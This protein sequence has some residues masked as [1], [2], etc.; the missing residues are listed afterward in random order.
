M[1]SREFELFRTPRYGYT[2]YAVG[3]LFGHVVLLP[4]ALI[5]TSEAG[6]GLVFGALFGGGFLVAL[7][8]PR[9]V[10]RRCLR[11]SRFYRIW[12]TATVA[13]LLAVAAP[14]VTGNL[15]PELF[16]SWLTLVLVVAGFVLFAGWFRRIRH[17]L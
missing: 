4:A 3:W 2:D 7:W 15:P 1:G 10:V 16:N 17:R 11:T 13:A 6:T 14:G 5:V 12:L 9:G 8:W